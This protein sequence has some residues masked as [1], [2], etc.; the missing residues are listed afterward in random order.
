MKRFLSL[1]CK[2]FPAVLAVFWLALA[3][4]P[5]P[6]RAL[7]PPVGAACACPP[8]PGTCG[9]LCALIGTTAQLTP[10]LQTNFRTY[11]DNAVE[12]I[13]DHS[14]P[15]L[16]KLVEEMFKSIDRVEER[17]IEWWQVMW[18]LDMRPALQDMAGQLGGVVNADQARAMA[19]VNDAQDQTVTQSEHQKAELADR[20]QLQTSDLM[21]TASTNVAGGGNRAVVL[22][23]AVREA[24]ERERTGRSLN[25]QGV[26]GDDGV[27]E[28]VN[29][30][31]KDYLAATCNPDANGGNA[32]CATPGRYPDAD[33][34][35]ARD[36]YNELTIDVKSDPARLT[37]L[38]SMTENLVGP[39][40][41]N[42]IPPAALNSPAGRE[43]LLM[44]RAYYARKDAAHAV[45]NYITSARMPGGRNGTWLKAM[46]NGS[47]LVPQSSLSDNPSYREI[48]HAM[49]IDRFYNGTYGLDILDEPSN[50]RREKLVQSTLYLM[51]L[52]DYYELLERMALVLAVQLSAMS[53]ERATG[54]VSQLQ[55][56]GP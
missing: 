17:L 41:A 37:A 27:A 15:A 23:R 4:F 40:M 21:C 56:M 51:Q 46:R 20:Q 7:I 54:N 55:P 53:D 13:K 50:V 31:W 12:D 18:Y 33:I 43:A 22:A 10:N 49:T 5:A 11:L 47:G 9:I 16:D 34:N 19:S 24:R 38:E 39:V 52:R 14:G 6:A 48:M 26:P 36:F 44:R 32:G 1:G 3:S 28:S 30:K 42:P 29:S 45:P 8:I 25:K 35:V 2:T